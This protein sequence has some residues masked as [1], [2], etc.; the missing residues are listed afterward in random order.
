[1]AERRSREVETVILARAVSMVLMVASHARLSQAL[2]EGKYFYG[3]LDALLALSG[4]TMATFSFT[5]TTSDTLRSF[6]RYGL[7]LLVPCWTIMVIWDTIVL[8]LGAKN[9]TLTLYFT[10]LA[11]I[12]NWF[13][14]HRLVLFHV[15]YPQAMAQML[16]FLALIFRLG[17]LTPMIR[18]HPVAVTAT[19]LAVALAMAVVSHALWNT[20]YLADKLPHLVLWNFML[21][22][23]LWAMMRNGEDGIARKLLLSA[24]IIGCAVIAYLPTGAE[25]GPVRAVWFVVIVLPVIWFRTV[26][27]PTFLAQ[28]AVLVAQASFWIFLAHI[29]LFDLI[30]VMVKPLG[31]SRGLPLSLLELAVGLAAP[32]LGW[33]WTTASIRVWY[34]NGQRGLFPL[35]FRRWTRWS[36]QTSPRRPGRKKAWDDTVT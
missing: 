9:V 19:A 33:A 23:F 22:W 7:R 30:E 12:S 14:H 18:R 20:L 8:A 5:G 2:F 26:R 15:W 31:I 16:L 29:F 10:E 28:P 4:M 35:A 32:I 24:V 6:L 1:M 25:F 17:N 3:G 27:L 13:T 36:P 21:G 34:S 11:L